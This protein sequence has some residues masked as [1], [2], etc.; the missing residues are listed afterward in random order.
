MTEYVYDILTLLHKHVLLVSN[1]T[2]S[3]IY[4]IRNGKMNISENYIPNTNFNR[5]FYYTI[6]SKRSY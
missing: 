5:Y 1:N 4:V 6:T 2:N 3:N